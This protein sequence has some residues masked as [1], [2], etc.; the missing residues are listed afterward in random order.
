MEKIKARLVPA[1][2]DCVA[3]FVPR[4]HAQGAIW[5]CH[6]YGTYHSL[7]HLA[8]LRDCRPLF[9]WRLQVIHELVIQSVSILWTSQPQSR[10][11]YLIQVFVQ[12]NVRS[13]WNHSHP[14][15]WILSLLHQFANASPSSICSDRSTRWASVDETGAITTSLLQRNLPL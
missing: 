7:A 10:F 5:L 8:N 2:K 12:F 14:Q 9:V 11:Q 3:G 15:S 4:R 13:L 6:I 1:N